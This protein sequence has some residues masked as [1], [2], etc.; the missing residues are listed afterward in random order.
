MYPQHALPQGAYPLNYMFSAPAVNPT[1]IVPVSSPVTTFSFSDF[2]TALPSPVP[3]VQPSIPVQ[4]ISPLPPP[5]AP[6]YISQEDQ[7]YELA[8]RLV[9]EDIAAAK[10]SS[11]PSV[12][13][14]PV[15]PAVTDSCFARQLDAEERRK[16][17]YKQDEEL[18]KKLDAEE[19]RKVQMKKD[20][21]LAKK[22]SEEE[23]RLSQAE[24]KKEKHSHN[25]PTPPPLPSQTVM[26]VH[27]RNHMINVH[28]RHCNCGNVQTFH[29]NH[30][31]KIHTQYCNCNVV[32][33]ANPHYFAYNNNHGRKHQHD[34]RCCAINHIHSENCCCAYRNH[35]HGYNC[36]HLNHTH[37]ELCHCSDK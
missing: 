20:E 34:H 32:G 27:Q 8:R 31:M 21:E 6:A 13:V 3:T 5:T 12:P 37:D 16:L 17:Q 7:D 28:N 15:S 35:K 26:N 9:L 36:C 19:K 10:K 4:I 11:K 18:A 33:N 25:V 30:L 1:V 22:L 14:A 24:I 29:N 23:N 2:A